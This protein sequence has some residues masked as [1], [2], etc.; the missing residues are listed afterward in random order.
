MLNIQSAQELRSESCLSS[1]ES[2]GRAA[3]TTNALHDDEE[4]LGGEDDDGVELSAVDLAGGEGTDPK[5]GLDWATARDRHALEGANLLTKPVNCPP[6]ICCLLPCLYSLPSMRTFAASVP[7]DALV[8]REGEW[9][10][11]EASSVVRGDVVLLQE[12]ETAPADF[13]VLSSTDDFEISLKAV[14]GSRMTHRPGAEA[15]VAL[16]AVCLRGNCR[17]VVTAI[18]D[19]TLLAQRL[20]DGKWPPRS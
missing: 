8:L 6:V 2:C 4:L 5:R 3:M 10:D 9:C 14:N 15:Q 12:G 7:E 17:G 19:E 11:V 1:Q 16:G 20:R 18:A 13:S